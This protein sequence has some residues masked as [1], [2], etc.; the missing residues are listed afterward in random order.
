[1]KKLK[2]LLV[3]LGFV[4][5]FSSI[6]KAGLWDGGHPAGPDIY[7]VRYTTS[8]V[9]SISTT[10]VLVSISS[11]A[12]PHPTNARAIIID[13]IQI[14][15]DKAAATTSAIKI[16]VVREVN[17]SSGTIV[18]FET[19]NN[20]LN[21]SNTNVVQVVG[22]EGGGLNCRVNNV[23]LAWGANLGSTPYILSNDTTQSTA[24]NTGS[25]LSSVAVGTFNYVLKVGD[26]VASIVDGAVAAVVS[27]QVRYHVETQ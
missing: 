20:T 15:L 14:E 12:W 22:Y 19:M 17:A 10:T 9:A 23:P 25:P 21:V 5:C 8:A 26:I 3:A 2:Q 4:F 16:G 24:L 11:S 13:Q 18:W 7:T 6:S 27:I 1:M